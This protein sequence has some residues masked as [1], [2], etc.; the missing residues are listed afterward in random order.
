MVRNDYPR[1]QSKRTFWQ[2]LNGDYLFWFDDEEKTNISNYKKALDNA[3]K[4]N[5]PFTYQCELSGINIKEMHD[6]MW[7]YRTFDIEEKTL[8]N[9]AI[10]HFNAV[11]NE[12]DIYINDL[13]VGSHKGGYNHFSFDVTKFLKLKDNKLLIKVVD[14]YDPEQPRGKQYW[15]ETGS[16]CWYNSNSG[17]W[18]S[19]WLE[20]FNTNYIDEYYLT[21]NLDKNEIKVEAKTKYQNDDLL[22]IEIYYHEQKVKTVI[23][24]IEERSADVTIKVL[25]EDNID[26]LHVWSP[27]NPNLYDVK[28]SLIKDNKVLDQIDTYFAFRKVHVLDNDIYLNNIKLYQRLI[29]DQGYFKG[30]DITAPNGECFKQDIELAKKMGFNGARKHQKIED[31]YFYYYADKLGF[32]VWGEIPSAYRF[33]YAE[34]QNVTNLIIDSIKQLYNHPSVITFVLFNESWGVRK[35]LTLDKHKNYARSMYY[36]AK[37]MDESRLMDTNDGWEQIS[38]TD[39][40]AVHDYDPIGNRFK[41][42]LCYDNINSVQPMWRRAMSFNEKT[43]Q[44]PII[45]TEFGGL[46]TRTDVNEDFFGYSVMA[47]KEEFYKQLNNLMKNV[48]SC[49]INGFCYTQLT[50]CK[51]ETNG[52]LNHDHE[53]KYDL[54]I[55][56]EIIEGRYEK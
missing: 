28:L 32:L 14:R 24:S 8:K 41:E 30:G 37:S 11:D 53:P 4:I 39:F 52:L 33:N 13:Y 9:G 48:Y 7:Y 38:D 43:S 21:P 23:T 16:R 25:E 20:S 29:L 45:L 35:I 34:N 36:L 22:K 54:E 19:V 18:Q 31:P 5:V 17:I 47:D 27:E 26:E 50:D 40:I 42:N 56:R 46:S 55:I 1:P 15:N 44:K 6:I 51:Q 10:L 49:S 12:C 2:S 3:L